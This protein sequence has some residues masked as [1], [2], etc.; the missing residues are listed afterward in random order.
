MLHTTSTFAR[1][2]TSPLRRGLPI[3]FIVALI[4]LLLF[5][6]GV[7]AFQ[8][9]GALAESDLY[10]VLVG[11]LDG[12]VGG[13]GIASSLHYDNTFGFG[14]LAAFY[15]F[16]DPAT[17]RDPDKLMNLINQVGFWFMLIG[18]L[19]FWCA[20]SV[21][22]GARA[23]TVALIIFAL[24]PMILELGTSGHP[25]IPM[26]ALLC[27]GATLLFLPVTGW[28][29]ALAAFGGSVFLVAGLMTRGEIFLAFP[30][31][32]LTRVDTRSPRGFFVSCILRSVAPVAAIIVFLILQRLF[33]PN[34]L[35][36][37]V[38]EYF[39]RW[40]SFSIIVVGLVYVALG[41]GIAT[42][43]VGG[44]AT[45]WLAWRARPGD[46]GL[47]QAGM[48][49]FLG[50]AALVLVPLGFFLPNAAGPTRHFMLT[51]AGFSILIAVALTA[52]LAMRRVVAL[53]VALLLGAANQVLAE[54]VRL[55]VLAA[56]D[57]RSPYRPIWTGYLTSTHAPLGWEWRRHDALAKRHA[58]WQAEGNMLATPC[59]P[60]TIIL[61]DETSELASR[62]YAGSTPVE[63]HRERFDD[64]RARLGVQRSKIILELQKAA[65][66][67]EDPVALIL[68]DPAY[69]DYKLYQDPYTLS[70][71]DR[72]PIPPDRQAQFG[73]R[74]PAP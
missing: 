73:C 28:R 53:G 16:A 66:W 18:L 45:L 36:S 27:A 31:L 62:L 48:A 23:G 22:H 10:R 71:Y 20:A 44:L 59:Q 67:P 63:A 41:C 1:L 37:T 61:T 15:A 64:I 51:Y 69:D 13:T 34:Q 38:D 9:R 3:D 65:M 54:I 72:T 40:F 57:A 26:F 50:P 8:Y 19:C 39:G 46:D 49:Q 42:A 11:L 4:F 7:H 14:Y 17:L 5:A 25:V 24:G 30:W 58:L 29:A 74:D 55:P 32:V 52:G 6:I 68:A 56:N 35:G 43:A 60:R 33:V 2:V 12:E 21:A 47:G 70:K